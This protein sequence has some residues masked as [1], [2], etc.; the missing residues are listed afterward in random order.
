MKT[1]LWSTST[2]DK[3]FSKFIRQRDEHCLKCKT[4]EGLTNSHYWRRGHS[5]TRFDPDNCIAL[6]GRCHSLWENLKNREYMDFMIERL[7]QKKYTE[8]E[9]KARSFKRREDAVR[10]CM[11]LLAELTVV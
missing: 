1:K 8:L 4:T 11:T 6:C 2:A 7:G 9:R 3:Y 5:A 10:E